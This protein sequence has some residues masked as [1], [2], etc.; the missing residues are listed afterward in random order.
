MTW[1]LLNSWESNQGT[2]TSPAQY[3]TDISDQVA[4]HSDVLLK[5]N[6]SGRY[7]YYW[8]IDDV[9]ITT[10]ATGIETNE[11]IK[12]I[13]YPNPSDGVFELRLN[14]AYKT[15]ELNVVD[16]SGNVLFHTALNSTQHT[17]DLSSFSPGVYIARVIIDDKPFYKKLVCK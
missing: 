2:E 13:V 14:K 17:I 3:S 5:W 11:E 6:Y 1:L 8:M 16:L 12:A 9:E 10:V 7:G 4:G 15:A